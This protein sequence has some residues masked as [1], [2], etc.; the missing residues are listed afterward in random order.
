MILNCSRTRKARNSKLK[1]KPGKKQSASMKRNNR[2]WKPRR[3]RK[4]R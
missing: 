2:R 4:P 3:S 1:E